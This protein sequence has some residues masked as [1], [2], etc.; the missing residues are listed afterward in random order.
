M[1]LIVGLRGADGV[2]LASDS[3]GTHGALR[4]SVPKLFKTDSGVIWGTAGPLAG[5][6]ALFTEFEKATLEP[7]P[8]RED[9]KAGIAAA[10]RASASAL[11]KQEREEGF[12]GLFAWFDSADRRHYLLLARGDGHTEFMTPYGAIGSS[13]HLGHFGF[14]RSAFMEYR[15][16][17]LETVK[18]LTYS[19]A[20]DVVKAS[21]KGVDGPI[22]MAVVNGESA[23]VLSGDEIQ[24]VG[25]TAAAFQLYQ[26]EHVKRV[27]G[28]DR[29][30]GHGGIVPGD[31]SN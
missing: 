19:V 11:V 29:E 2:V 5:M 28:A 26:L 13:R 10:M 27:G 24:P 12:E 23:A 31:R 22:Q 4:R 20:E 16:L 15:T 18:M 7:N 30:N 25:G 3:Q 21:A 17:Q 14:S 6:Q 1:T 8:R 9:A